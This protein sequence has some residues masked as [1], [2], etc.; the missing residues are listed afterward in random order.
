MTLAEGLSHIRVICDILTRTPANSALKK[1]TMKKLS[2]DWWSV[3]IA[4]AIAA[5]IKL[6]LTPAIPW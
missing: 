1:T 5:L 2:V 6:G 4:L 3:L